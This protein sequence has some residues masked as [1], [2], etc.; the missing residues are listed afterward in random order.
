MLPSVH[1]SSTRAET[2]ALLVAALVERPLHLGIDNRAVV[3]R[4]EQ[5]LQGRVDLQRKPWGLRCDGD[6]WER[7]HDALEQ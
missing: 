3:T 6:L 1:G 5:L 2:G 4:L 7:V